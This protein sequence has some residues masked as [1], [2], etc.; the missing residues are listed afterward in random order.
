M[1][2]YQQK[3]TR[4]IEVDIN[5]GGRPNRQVLYII[6]PFLSWEQVNLFGI[7]E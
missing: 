4:R 1:S 2:R 3:Q 5:Y 7:F 6:Y